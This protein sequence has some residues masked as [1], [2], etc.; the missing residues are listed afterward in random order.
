MF[1]RCPHRRGQVGAAGDLAPVGQLQPVLTRSRQHRAGV[2]T[3]QRVQVFPAFGSASSARASATVTLVTPTR[4][5]SVTTSATGSTAWID[6]A[7]YASTA[8]AGTS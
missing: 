6:P 7:T 8:L 4:C 3:Q 1:Q 5:R 2:H